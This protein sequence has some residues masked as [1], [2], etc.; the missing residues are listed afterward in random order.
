M[1][2]LVFFLGIGLSLFIFLLLLARRGRVEGAAEILVDARQALFALQTELLP[3]GLVRRIFSRDDLEFVLST[4]SPEIRRIFL[5]ERNR[6][7]IMWVERVRG[8]IELL[9]RL[10]LGSARFYARLEFR[11]EMA[12]AWNFAVL[13][14][15]C[16]ALQMAF[17]VGGAYTTPKI[18]GTVADAA[19]RVCEISGQ[20]LA[21]MSKSG[22]E[23]FTGRSSAV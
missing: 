12:L 1:T 20:S 15:S 16:R 22:L 18:V 5:K 9:R 3:Q 4:D 17:A 7:A 23:N 6:V 11:S 2:Q 8:H 19:T 10:H 21:F 14:V 13:L